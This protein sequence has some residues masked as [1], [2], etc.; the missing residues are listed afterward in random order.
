MLFYKNKEAWLNE[1][2]YYNYSNTFIKKQK[3][4]S[5]STLKTIQKVSILYAINANK[6]KNEKF[7]K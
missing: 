5:C 7:G 3:A 2:K 4:G 1:N 6:I